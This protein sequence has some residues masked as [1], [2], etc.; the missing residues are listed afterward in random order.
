MPATAPDSLPHRSPAADLSFQALVECADDIITVVDADGRI[1][2]DSPAVQRVL[3]YRQGELVGRNA[4]ELVHADDLGRAF[5]LLVQTVGTPG[6]SGSLTF[7]FQHRDASWRWLAAT[8]RLLGAGDASRLVITSRDVTGSVQAGAPEALAATGL[9]GLGSE[10]VEALQLEMLQRLALAAEFRDDD[11][12]QHTRRVGELSAALARTVGLPE[13]EV[14][15]V[16]HAAPLHDLGKIGIRD[17]IL[18]KPG[19]LSPEE[20]EVMRTHTVLGARLLARGRSS[21]VRVA[22]SIALHHHERWDGGGYP[23]GLM[24]DSIPFTARIVAVVDFYDALTHDRPYRPAWPE[25]DVLRSLGEEGG[26]RFD[27][28]VTEAFLDLLAGQNS[29]S[30]EPLAATLEAP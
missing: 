11:T 18:L 19:P 29:A 5:S 28:S 21:L 13:A 30:P 23:A 4:F 3:G 7:R 22:E 12:G 9:V 17:S 10:A 8:G 6:A 26:A 27:P 2:Y 15:L 16:R 1:V 20:L 24:G 14:E 25:T